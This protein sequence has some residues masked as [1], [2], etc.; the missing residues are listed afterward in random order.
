M[1]G[2]KVHNKIVKSY[3][4]NH[5]SGKTC[6]TLYNDTLGELTAPSQYLSE[7]ADS[8]APENSIYAAKCDLTN[9]YIFLLSIREADFQ[10]FTY[11]GPK[12]P[13]RLAIMNFADFF[14]NG[15]Y[16][17]NEFVTNIAKRISADTHSENTVGRTVSSINNFLKSS[18]VLQANLLDLQSDGLIDLE[19]EKH[20]EFL[21]DLARKK[22]DPS[23][24]QKLIS[25]SVIASVIKHGPQYCNSAVISTKGLTYFNES[26][27]IE[28]T[29][30]YEKMP[31]ILNALEKS[32]IVHYMFYTVLAG[33]GLRVSEVA[34]L[35]IED[36]KIDAKE[37]KISVYNPK[38]RM[39]K[40][41]SL[42]T[43]QKKKLAWKGRASSTVYF[44]EPYNTMFF[45]NL[46]KFLTERTKS[47]AEH[48][49]FFYS[50][51]SQNKGAPIVGSN[52]LNDPFKEAQ[53]NIGMEPKYTLHSLRHMYCSWC[54]N[55]FPH[56][57][58]DFGLPLSVVQTMVG[59]ASDTTT[60][61]YA[62]IDKI[63]LEATIQASG[64]QLRAIGTNNISETIRDAVLARVPD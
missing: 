52:A 47:G 25:K 37:R 6:Y 21:K 28:K 45:N 43:K 50:S 11:K 56:P 57:T 35:L 22:L 2:A 24:K 17:T 27:I 23:Q 38:T 4:Y 10:C 42:S 48:R 36:I 41:Q 8:G 61:I 16:S 54:L 3:S 53:I 15:E 39:A 59:H 62:I 49:L 5:P 40:Y 1:V 60:S 32:N 63:M 14:A 34:Q 51:S 18:T 55:F 20:N 29:F 30:P 44:I 46:G 58:G 7:L 33:T 9:F 19:L 26:N 64:A 31:K 12:S 13:L